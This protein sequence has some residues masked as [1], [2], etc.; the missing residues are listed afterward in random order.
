MTKLSSFLVFAFGIF[1]IAAILIISFKRS[2]PSS[3]S[4]SGNTEAVVPQ[5][6]L[7]PLK[8]G[9]GEQFMREMD[10][11]F[12]SG[13]MPAV[14]DFVE[15]EL[16]PGRLVIYGRADGAGAPQTY[17]LIDREIRRCDRGGATLLDQPPVLARSS[18]MLR[19]EDNEGLETWQRLE[20]RQ[21][22]SITVWWSAAEK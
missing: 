17:R 18:A 4:A 20:A 16:V 7:S 21:P 22:Y 8:L 14:R 12:A 13:G 1:L 19:I 15:T 2:T 5:S 6:K 9:S 10:K 11:L 3:S